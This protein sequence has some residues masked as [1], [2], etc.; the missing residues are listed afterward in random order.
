MNKQELTQALV[1]RGKFRKSEPRKAAP[2]VRYA[3]QQITGNSSIMS[4]MFAKPEWLTEENQQLFNA[5]GAEHG[6]CSPT[7]ERGTVIEVNQ[8]N[9]TIEVKNYYGP[10]RGSL[11][12]ISSTG[13]D[14]KL[15]ALSWIDLAAIY[16]AK[17][18]APFSF[19]RLAVLT[20]LFESDVPR[21]I[22]ENWKGEKGLR[23][24][25]VRR[26]IA[27]DYLGGF[28]APTDMYV[29]ACLEYKGLDL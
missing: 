21:Q 11:A 28:N 23:L 8:L 10:G 24:G 13:L 20:A 16:M 3:W 29:S 5:I 25:E 15:N 27:R 19:D 14:D 2:F 17:T 26:V 4:S 9:D 22:A 12:Q 18:K 7:G 1:Y 6:F